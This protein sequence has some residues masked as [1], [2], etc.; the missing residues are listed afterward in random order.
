MTNPRYSSQDLCGVEE[1]GTDAASHATTSSTPAT[2]HKDTATSTTPATA[3]SA[4]TETGTSTAT[5]AATITSTVAT[6]TDE[7][8]APYRTADGTPYLYRPADKHIS[9]PGIQHGHWDEGKK[10]PHS[11]LYITPH[12]VAELAARTAGDATSQL[13]VSE[14][15]DVCLTLTH[16]GV[17]ELVPLLRV[18][19]R[20]YMSDDEHRALLEMKETDPDAFAKLTISHLGEDATHGSSSSKRIDFRAGLHVTSSCLLMSC[21][22][23]HG[24]VS[25]LCLLH[26]DRGK[27]VLGGYNVAPSTTLYE[28]LGDNHAR[29]ICS[30]VFVQSFPNRFAAEPATPPN[31]LFDRIAHE[32]CAILHPDTQRCTRLR[33][34]ATEGVL[35]RQLQREYPVERDPDRD[36]GDDYSEEDDDDD[37]DE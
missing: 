4:A 16:D 10:A 14:H 1:D 28:P 31:E 6:S 27:D 21:H 24:I 30:D 25:V 3:T 11:H 37:D 26:A 5:P 20:I 19:K 32:M 17:T 8:Q 13:T 34:L 9:K 7:K 12:I 33:L 2:E 36:Y 23:A 15:H 29:A 22:D 35:G 18:F